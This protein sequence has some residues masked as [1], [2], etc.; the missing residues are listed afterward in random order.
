MVVYSKYKGGRIM[1]NKA[2]IQSIEFTINW[3]G[4][5]H[6]PVTMENTFSEEEMFAKIDNK[7]G[8]VEIDGEVVAIIIKQMN[9]FIDEL[10]GKGMLEKI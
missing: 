2:M 10:K 5:H 6:K 7:K 9:K 3:V 4:D 1:K 8:T